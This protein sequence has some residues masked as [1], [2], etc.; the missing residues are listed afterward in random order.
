MSWETVIALAPSC[1]FFIVFLSV[2]DVSG[3]SKTAKIWRP[4]RQEAVALGKLV[5]KELK[6]AKAVIAEN[7]EYAERRAGQRAAYE[8]CA[9]G[10]ICRVLL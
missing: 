6:T 9:T 4:I 5:G 10:G 1:V 7:K 8:V 2:D 3:L